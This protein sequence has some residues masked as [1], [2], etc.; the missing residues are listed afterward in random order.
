MAVQIPPWFGTHVCITHVQKDIIWSYVPTCPHTHTHTT[1]NPY[2]YTPT[3]ISAS[4]TR[5]V[6]C[7]KSWWWQGGE[8]MGMIQAE[9][10]NDTGRRSVWSHMRCYK[11]DS[12]VLSVWKALAVCGEAWGGPMQRGSSPFLI[13]LS[14]PLVLAAGPWSRD[15]A[16]MWEFSKWRCTY[17]CFVFNISDCRSSRWL[18]ITCSLS[19]VIHSTEPC[20]R[21]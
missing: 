20:L 3:C 10:Q 8:S 19:P 13:L 15:W 1:T 17:V 14:A 2:H 12:L 6:L 21:L 16:E 4:V 18:F 11:G 7:S 9:F 5:V